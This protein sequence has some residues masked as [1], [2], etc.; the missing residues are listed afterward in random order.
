LFAGRWLN[1]LIF[2]EI[3]HV[4]GKQRRIGRPVNYGDKKRLIRRECGRFTCQRAITGY[5]RCRSGR[6][7]AL[8]DLKH[9][10][11]QDANSSLAAT[12]RAIVCGG[13]KWWGQAVLCQNAAD[14]CRKLHGETRYLDTNYHFALA[15]IERPH[16]LR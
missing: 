2:S 6:C 11:M 15:P 5:C 7:P 10:S 14:V 4:S 9:G 13:R 16:K 12:D 3:S 8:I 1:R